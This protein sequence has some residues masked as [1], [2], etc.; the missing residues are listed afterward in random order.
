MNK[1]Y[2]LPLILLKLILLTT[3]KEKSKDMI[4]FTFVSKQHN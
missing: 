4:M 1:V 2:Y 3:N